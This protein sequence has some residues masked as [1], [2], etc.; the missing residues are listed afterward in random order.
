MNWKG[1]KG[2]ARQL[3]NL[4]G[5]ETGCL[6]G[7]GGGALEILRLWKETSQYPISKD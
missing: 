1:N 5:K 7:W 6:H 2:L 4:L 3:E